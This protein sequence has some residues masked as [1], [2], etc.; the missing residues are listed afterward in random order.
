MDGALKNYD[1]QGPEKQMSHV[2]H[3]GI[4]VFHLQICML[5]W[6]YCRSQETRKILLG[7]ARIRE[8]DDRTEEI[9]K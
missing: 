4:L 6:S 8:E 5:T 1:E 9:R 7:V 2:L 3:F